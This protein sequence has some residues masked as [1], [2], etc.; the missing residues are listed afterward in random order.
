MVGIILNLHTRTIYPHF[1]IVFDYMFTTFSYAQNDE[2]LPKIWT[3][4]ITK[5]NARLRVSI[6]EE[7]IPNLSSKW[8]SPDEVQDLEA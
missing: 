5:P 3:N 6:D 4:M 1:H 2:V 7:T 8:L